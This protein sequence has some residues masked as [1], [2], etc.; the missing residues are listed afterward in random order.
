MP[1]LHQ[2]SLLTAGHNGGKGK[3]GKKDGKKVKAGALFM[4]LQK[5]NMIV[6]TSTHVGIGS[7]SAPHS[8]VYEK[9][10]L[11]QKCN[12]GPD[13]K[14]WFYAMARDPSGAYKLISDSTL[15]K[16]ARQYPREFLEWLQ[17]DMK[18]N[19]ATR[20]KNSS[21]SKSPQKRSRIH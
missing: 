17:A 2:G 9:K 15:P 6:N 12:C 14:D 3:D 18:K 7:L 11:A 5:S 16:N 1:Y 10:V 13:D 4:H 8:D 21:Q 19:K 20:E